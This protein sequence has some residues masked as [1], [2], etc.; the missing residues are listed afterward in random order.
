[1]KYWNK[2]G[3]ESETESEERQRFSNRVI[4]KENMRMKDLSFVKKIKR[5][6]N[7]I[8]P[9]IKDRFQFEND[10]DI[11]TKHS[12]V[13]IEENIIMTDTEASVSDDETLDTTQ[14]DIDDEENDDESVES[15]ENEDVI[16]S[17]YYLWTFDACF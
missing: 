15:D 1:M 12:T 11:H 17:F 5:K 7:S 3:D 13:Q 14:N 10:R 2:K 9:D 16:G 6:T 4:Q 8:K